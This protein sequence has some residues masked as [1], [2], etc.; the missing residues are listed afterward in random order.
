MTGLVPGL[1]AENELESAIA[2]D[3]D[4]QRGWAFP[5]HGP[6]HP[7]SDV[8]AHVA[9]ILSNISAT[10]ELR[11][12]LRVIAL[13]H[14]SMKWAVSHDR[15]WSPDNDHAILARRVAERHTDDPKLLLTVELHDEAY[16]IFT[17]K[18]TDAD[19]LNELLA[20]VPDTELYI[21]F[22]ELDGSTEGKDPTFLLWLRGEFALRGLLPAGRAETRAPGGRD[23]TIFM[24]VWET[25]PG[26]Q[27]PFADAIAAA[28]TGAVAQ[29]WEQVQVLKSA[30]G[31][32]V[33]WL[34]HT[35]MPN[36]VALI[37]G[38][39]FEQRVAELVDQTGARILEARVLVPVEPAPPASS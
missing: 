2:S 4:V 14:D 18:R 30:D 1:T 6:G 19:A 10:D 33:L 38:R 27:V 15:P 20:R 29:E 34:G 35:P 22:V 31:W 12:R 9:A 7:E 17:S 11:A 8:G 23:R 5:V 13:V 21:R 16:W 37:R 25:E 28:T 39:P 24:V 3:A 36:D 26:R 32:R